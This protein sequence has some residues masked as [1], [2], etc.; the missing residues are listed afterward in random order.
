MMLPERVMPL[1]VAALLATGALPKTVA[2]LSRKVTVPVK[3]L[4]VPVIVLAEAT[5]A[6]KDSAAPTVSVDG[7][8]VTVVT[9]APLATT[10]VTAC[11][12]EVA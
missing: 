7:V 4:I 6:V 9:V 5:V 3:E 8:A 11:D 1:S 10:N 12:V 2:P